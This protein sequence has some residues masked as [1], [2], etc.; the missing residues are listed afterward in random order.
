MAI[1]HA[2]VSRCGVTIAAFLHLDK[3]IDY[4]AIDH[5]PVD[6]LFALVVPE[7]S[8]EE[9]LQMLAHLAEMFSNDDIREQLRNGKDCQAKYELMANWQS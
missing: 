4:D 8:T 9:H 6:L 1:P 2:R 5:Q 3:G 7:Q